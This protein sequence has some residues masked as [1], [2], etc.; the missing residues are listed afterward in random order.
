ME[1]YDAIYDC[2][3]ATD[4]ITSQEGR[5]HLLSYLKFVT[6]LL[7]LDENG[8][9]VSYANELSDIVV[10]IV[11][12]NEDEKIKNLYSLYS[13]H[14]NQ[15]LH[16]LSRIRSREDLTK[17]REEN[18]LYS[19][20]DNRLHLLRPIE[21][22]VKDI[23]HKLKLVIPKAFEHKQPQHENEINDVIKA[24]IDSEKT[25]YKRE[26]PSIRFSF[27][28]I[29]PDHYVG[30]ENLIIE[31]KFV[32]KKDARSKI[33]NELSADLFKLPHNLNKLLII[34]DPER[35]IV[36]ELEFKTD[37]ERH[38]NVFLEVIR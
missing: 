36:D 13:K 34:F 35:R 15:I 21:I 28:N 33:T 14:A 1:D 25:N 3:I 19:I 11:G 8:F 30:E 9:L 22:A 32:R 29:I 16:S 37:F 31:A 2:D 23:A 5:T 18:T 6:D 38:D 27:S 4:Q 17:H 20:L 7:P 26:F 24:F 10:D 12:A